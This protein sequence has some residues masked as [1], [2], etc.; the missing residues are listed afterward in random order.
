MNHRFDTA[1][2]VFGVFLCEFGAGKS[3]VP[4]DM[5]NTGFSVLC[6]FGVGKCDVY[7][8]MRNAGFSVWCEFRFEKSDCAKKKHWQ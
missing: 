4:L 2:S 1:D 5:R 6:E 7:D 8:D 3:D